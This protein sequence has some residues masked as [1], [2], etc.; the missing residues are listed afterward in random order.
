[1]PQACVVESLLTDVSGGAA[2]HGHGWGVKAASQSKV[3]QFDGTR[4]V[5]VFQYE[6]F[7]LGDTIPVLLPSGAHPL[8]HPP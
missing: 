5:L 6:V 2:P 4:I 3:D 1:M 7:R 8:P